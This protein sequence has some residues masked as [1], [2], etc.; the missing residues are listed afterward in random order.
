MLTH[1][2]SFILGACSGVAILSLFVGAGLGEDDLP[3]INRDL[4]KG[5]TD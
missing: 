3:E 2:L 5:G 1:I 4:L